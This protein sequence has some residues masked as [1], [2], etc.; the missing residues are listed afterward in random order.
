MILLLFTG[1]S[2]EGVVGISL[3]DLP[4]ALCWFSHLV[5][6][7]EMVGC[8]LLIKSLLLEILEHGGSISLIELPRGIVTYWKRWGL[9]YAIVRVLLETLGCF[10]RAE[11][12]S[13]R[14]RLVSIYWIYWKLW[15]PILPS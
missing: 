7:L 15:G 6:L 14:R 5:Q 9:T 8:V 2:G 12:V 3:F 4:L 11:Q 1:N 13:I 10:V